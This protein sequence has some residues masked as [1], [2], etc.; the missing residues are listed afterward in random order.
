MP[1]LDIQGW[2]AKGAD[3]ENPQRGL[4]QASEQDNVKK[5]MILDTS[6]YP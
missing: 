5:K 2:S 3:P 4:A 6:E 1:K